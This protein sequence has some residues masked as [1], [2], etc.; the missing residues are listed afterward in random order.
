YE[1]GAA[2][3][4]ALVIEWNEQGSVRLASAP[5][6]GSTSL[7]AGAY[8]I[9]LTRVQNLT[10]INSDGSCTHFTDCQLP[11]FQKDEFRLRLPPDVRLISASLNGVEIDAP[12]VQNRIC[13]I[14]LPERSANQSGHHIA[15]R[16]A[17][18]SVLL[19][20]VDTLKLPLPEV[21]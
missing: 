21:F 7:S 18:P 1:A 19:G 15:L 9:G 14:R 20:F 17:Y 12:G 4:P 5:V 13:R 8:G 2:N 3:E 16:L 10:I 11:A 6:E